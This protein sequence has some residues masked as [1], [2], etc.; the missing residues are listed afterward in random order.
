MAAADDGGNGEVLELF[1][2]GKKK[3]PPP[4]ALTR[5]VDPGEDSYEDLKLLHMGVVVVK[6]GYVAQKEYDALHGSVPG[7]GKSAGRGG[8]RKWPPHRDVGK[9]L[10]NKAE[11][12]KIDGFFADIAKASD[13]AL[14]YKRGW[15]RVP[16]LHS[17]LMKTK[18]EM[19]AHPV[20]EH[21]YLG[22]AMG[23][24]VSFRKLK[25]MYDSYDGKTFAIGA[26][27]LTPDEIDY[28]RVMIHYADDCA[29]GHMG[30]F[31]KRTRDQYLKDTAKGEAGDEET[32][33]EAALA[34]FRPELLRTWSRGM[35]Q[36]MANLGLGDRMVKELEETRGNFQAWEWGKRT[37]A[38]LASMERKIASR[39]T[40]Q[41]KSF[42][43]VKK[44]LDEIVKFMVKNEK[45]FQAGFAADRD[46]TEE[47]FVKIGSAWAYAATELA[48]YGGRVEADAV[49]VDFFEWLVSERGERGSAAWREVSTIHMD[50]RGRR[51]H[52]RLADSLRATEAAGLLGRAVA[53]LEESAPGGPLHRPGAIARDRWRIPSVKGNPIDANEEGKRRLAEYLKTHGLSTTGM[54][55]MEMRALAED[56]A[57]RMLADFRKRMKS[58]EAAAIVKS[59]GDVRKWPAHKDL[60]A[61]VAALE[62]CLRK[63][64]SRH[65][66]QARRGGGNDVETRV[67]AL[68][69]I[70]DFLLN[71][72]KALQAA[73]KSGASGKAM[74]FGLCAAL[75][76]GTTMTLAAHAQFQ[77]R[78]TDVPG[79]KGS[80]GDSWTPSTMS[81]NKGIAL[82]L[83]DQWQLSGPNRR[84]LRA[85]VRL[86]SEC[87][88]GRM[89]EALARVTSTSYKT[90]GGALVAAV[91][92][93]S[94]GA[95]PMLMRFFA[96][97]WYR[98]RDM[99]ANQMEMQAEFLRLSARLAADRNPDAAEKQRKA[100]E[101]FMELSAWFRDRMDDPLDDA[102]DDL[103]RENKALR[104]D[105]PEA[106]D[107]MSDA[108]RELD[109]VLA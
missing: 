73:A 23:C 38:T 33:I 68:R 47:L 28:L 46:K 32:M 5:S 24:L 4:R 93:L 43:K 87:G 61:C 15:E 30:K 25:M 100:A 74:Y 56:A 44:T 95:I 54:G 86:G 105:H 81:R 13:E 12:R 34:E 103:E 76:G 31:L 6:G 40:P 84:Y 42:A 102:V 29:S 49:D 77:S 9:T 66:S 94:I 101:R 80:D 62:K 55:G 10:S 39:G 106:A 36:L 16:K 59:G 109:D 65:R 1:G 97:A 26:G 22:L 98:T 58:P 64:P 53:E 60:S 41:A 99:L 57:D 82:V 91:V 48:V 71:N 70:D 89:R 37:S 69:R 3:R 7:P 96:L 51:M 88:S 19:F 35:R 85:V 67:D 107:Q 50:I 11:L 104:K 75:M 83:K 18:V 17:F 14:V 78:Q 72:R 52:G 21:V 45:S 27:S 20:G 108:E 8:Y 79:K 90:E 63:N 92:L 2:F